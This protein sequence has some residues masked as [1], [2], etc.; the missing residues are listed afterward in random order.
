MPKSEEVQTPTFRFKK[1]NQIRAILSLAHYFFWGAN[2]EI[3]RL[4]MGAKGQSF[5]ALNSLEKC[6][7]DILET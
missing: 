5:E 7:F 4:L 3:G 2:S 6:I 1:K